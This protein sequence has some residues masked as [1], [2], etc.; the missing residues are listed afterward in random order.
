MADK[1]IQLKDK[2]SNK[3]Y[4]KVISTSIPDGAVT[5]NKLASDVQKI[6][7]DSATNLNAVKNDVTVLKGDS[8]VTGSVDNKVK[9]AVDNLVGTAP[10]TLNTLQKIAEE[11][12]DPANNTA[13]TVLDQ[14]A[15]KADRN[16]L[17]KEIERAKAAE[18]LL[19]NIFIVNFACGSATPYYINHTIREIEEAF[20]KH[21]LIIVTG[22]DYFGIVTD[23]NS[24]GINGF[25]GKINPYFIVTE[26]GGEP[27]RSIS[28]D[29]S[30]HSIHNTSPNVV[31]GTVLC[32]LMNDNGVLVDT[33]DT[34]NPYVT[35]IRNEVLL[36]GTHQE[37]EITDEYMSTHYTDINVGVVE[38]LNYIA[39][40][41]KD[42][43]YEE[44][45]A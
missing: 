13:T 6:L 9:T 11:L 18:A 37:E 31:I 44:V 35:H 1:L 39:N 27:W 16:E 10:A 14:V 45:T 32:A 2:D 40:H 28:S 12:Q 24:S 5:N 36:G 3:L 25:S 19:D 7:N 34:E 29:D 41:F 42:L 30:N 20:S 33:I 8:S 43:S 21:K 26:F 15:N 4:P 38:R 17:E 22:L 23:V